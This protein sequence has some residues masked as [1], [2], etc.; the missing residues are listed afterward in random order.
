MQEDEEAWVGV[1]HCFSG[2]ARGWLDRHPK[3]DVAGRLESEENYVAQTFERF[4][5]ATALTRHVEFTTLA[6]GVARRTR[7]S[8]WSHP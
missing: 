7:K 5:Q 1:Q 6:A 8:E 3:R 4:W 2:L